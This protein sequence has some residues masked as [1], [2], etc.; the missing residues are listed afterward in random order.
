MKNALLLL[1]V[2]LLLSPCRA[3]ASDAAPDTSAASMI[4]Y[5]APSGRVL[6]S[7][8]PDKSMRM[9]S[10]TKLMTALV[11]LEAGDLASEIEILPE[12]TAVEG[13]SM[14]LKAGERYSLQ[15]LLTG[16]LLASGNDAALAIAESVSGSEAAFVARMNAR[17]AE[18]GMS[19]THFANPHGLDGEDHYST[20]RDLAVLM[21]CV[22]EQDTLRSIL[23]M[24][25]ASVRENV[26]VNHNRLLGRC[27]G[28]TGGKTGY[29]KAAGRCLV[30]SCC[31]DGLELICVTLSDPDD[32]QDHQ[33]MYDWGFARFR[34]FSVSEI[35]LS[36]GV[37]LIGGE[38]GGI[39]PAGEAAYCVD[40]NS[41]IRWEINLPPFAFAPGAPGERA[42]ELY[43]REDDAL[44]GRLPL[45]WTGERISDTSYVGLTAA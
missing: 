5:H 38:A 26:Y 27:E 36:P 45:V 14:N 3:E 41:K 24:R 19:H 1:L 10:T 33:A 43:I 8:D 12:W 9:A 28:M 17:A 34:S 32:W 4:L 25:I 22:L 16:L 20:A 39:A 29:T 11:A 21:G 37:P 15:E 13:S 40:R 42:G 30:S 6:A 2:S 18:L 31:R 35:D 23:G 44:L 7:K